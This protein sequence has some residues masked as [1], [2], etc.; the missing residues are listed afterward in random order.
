MQYKVIH[1]LKERRFINK[2]SKSEEAVFDYLEKH[3][4]SIPRLS[5]IELSEKSFTSQATINRACK[6]LGFNGYSELKYAIKEDLSFIET[7]S[8]ERINKTEFFLEKINF[9]SAK[10]IIKYFKGSYVKLLIYGLGGSEISAKYFQRQLLYLGIPTVFVSE[11]KMLDQFK[12]YVIV[13]FSSSG[14]TLRINQIA[15]KAKS[16]NMQLV[17]ITKKDSSLA[18]ISDGVFYHEVN[19]DKLDGISREQQIHMIIMVN[20]L[21]DQ[22]AKVL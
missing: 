5:V 2:I 18:Q 20:E 21:I 12:D 6:T 10:D 1:K 14:E 9:E 16:Y 11:I 8:Q 13:I 19:M 7:H 3:F 22:I 15:R 4:N 17:S